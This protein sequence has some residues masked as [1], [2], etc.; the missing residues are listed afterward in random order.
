MIKLFNYHL[1]SI[2]NIIN[3]LSISKS[4]ILL[5][6]T[7]YLSIT[8]IIGILDGFGLILLINLIFN[9]ETLSLFSNSLEIIS[10]YFEY[11][12]F[13]NTNS[14]L[15]IIILIFLFTIFFKIIIGLLDVFVWTHTRTKFQNQIYY[16]YINA[17]WSHIYDYKVGDVAGTLSWEVRA[18]SKYLQN[19]FK[20]L[21]YLLLSI[22][23]AILAILTDFLVSLVS[24]F[25][26]LPVLL[27]FLFVYKQL[28]Y[29]SKK[30][31]ERRNA[32]MSDITERLNG[33]FQIISEKRS[34]KYHYEKGIY[35]QKFLWT[36]EI[37]QGF[38]Q[39]VTATFTSIFIAFVV[40]C[41]Y[42]YNT[43]YDPNAIESIPIFASVG[44]LGI[45]FLSSFNNLVS[46][47]GNILRLTGSIEPVTNGLK[48]KKFRNT[49]NIDNK[50]YEITL[51]N[52]YFNYKKL[53]NIINNF[54][55]KIKVGE[56]L[57]I[58]GPSGSGK[59]TLANIIAGIYLPT[60][61]YVSYTDIYNN[62][63]SSKTYQPNIGYVT[64]NIH[65]F[66]GKIREFLSQDR[67]IDDDKIISILKSVDVYDFIQSIG[68]INAEIDESGRSFSG[69]QIKRLG[70]ARVLLAESN[71]IIFDEPTS[72]L[73]DKNKKFLFETLNHLSKN[74]I[75]I[76]ISHEKIELN[77]SLVI[78]L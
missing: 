33:L 66:R 19:I 74:Y 6:T 61:G 71:I 63:Y 35:E 26:A 67:K 58:T 12:N 38:Y 45:R 40:V 34:K 28:S 31:A 37:I 51:S 20:V 15:V 14:Y 17:D 25:L 27:V 3:L 46:G 44:V 2:L 48:L 78:K 60:S 24:G 10:K 76:I 22:I 70:I 21:Y 13:D 72:G 49:K 54:N 53:D 50:I 43:Y 16:N 59:S 1:S 4:K 30:E 64:Q 47:I 11:F 65:M 8:F 42:F 75:T 41:Y 55:L 36:L 32:F 73:D 69:G 5:F 9:N 7:L 56:P 68:G 29:L 52:V 39:T 77:E 23:F 18:I 62:N 57:I